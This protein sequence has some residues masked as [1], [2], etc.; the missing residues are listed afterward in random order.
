MT[1]DQERDAA[2]AIRRALDDVPEPV[3]DRI[4][5]DETIAS[6][7]AVPVVG[8]TEAGLV[9]PV[10]GV[11][12]LT[13]TTTTG[14]RLFATVPPEAATAIGAEL[15][16]AGIKAAGE[17]AMFCALGHLGITDPDRLRHAL[18]HYR[19]HRDGDETVSPGIETW[20]PE[21]PDAPA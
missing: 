14:R 1:D 6:V 17:E 16:E 20:L 21:A 3:G 13:V 4:D 11:V 15:V 7:Q 12:A 8:I 19:A 10:A 2:E 18:D 5:A 9:G